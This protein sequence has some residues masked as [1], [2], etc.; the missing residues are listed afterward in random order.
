M[1]QMDNQVSFSLVTFS[2]DGATFPT[3]CQWLSLQILGQQ[4]EGFAGPIEWSRDGEVGQLPSI[5][6][7]SGGQS[8]CDADL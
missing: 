8:R 4:R 1:R 5:A 6:P 2:A 3:S 7:S